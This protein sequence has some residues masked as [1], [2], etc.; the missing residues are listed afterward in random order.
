MPRAKSTTLDLTTKTLWP[1]KTE[2]VGLVFNLQAI[3]DSPLYPQYT[4]GLHAWFLQQIQQFDAELSAYLHDGESEKPFNLSGLSGQFVPHSR[5]LQLQKGKTY[6]WHLNALSARTVAGLERWLRQLPDEVALKNTPLQIKNVQVAHPPTTYAQL[7]RQGKEQ[8]GSVSLSFLS[9]TSF[10]RKGHH[11]PLPWPANVFHSY[12]RRWNHFSGESVDQDAFLDWIDNHVI[13]QRHHLESQKVAAG[14]RGSVTGFVGAIAYSLA[15]RAAEQP[16]F[17]T[18]FYTLTQLAPYCGTGHK[19]TF[20]LG[21]T[22][23]GWQSA[24]SLP[25]TA[26]VEALLAERIAELT[27]TFAAQRKRQGGDRA[28]NI[29]ET[30]ATV[31]ARRELGDSL[32]AIATDLEMP[33]ETVKTYSKLARRSLRGAN[34]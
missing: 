30:W 15:R 31:L 33:Y 2:L 22:R 1:K 10:R 24:L 17:Q 23:L 19:T 16:D 9:P 26:S 34:S 3:A 18:L 27:E 20:G 8:S 5:D 7:S 25:E 11:L 14:K 4:I 32:Q 28:Q 13:I 29:A 12:L 21:Q 6:Q